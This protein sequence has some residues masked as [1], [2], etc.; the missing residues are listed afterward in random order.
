MTNKTALVT[1]GARRIGAAI[2]RELHASG[3]H[4]IVHYNE[5]SD[6][7]VSLVSKMNNIKPGSAWMIQADLSRTDCLQTLIDEACA[8]N[9]R[10]DVLVNNASRFYPTPLSGINNEQWHDIMT[11]NLQAPLL[12][13]RLAA[14]QLGRHAGSIINLTD[15]YA[16]RP[17]KNYL[18]Y[19]VSKAGLVMLTQSLARELAPDVRVNAVS[20]G[21]IVWPEG[22]TP[23]QQH[24]VLK[25]VP[26]G[27]EGEVTDVARAVRYLVFDADYTTGQ[28]LTMDGGRSLFP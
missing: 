12:L 19:S 18:L 10:L 2:C 20:P 22:M 7:A 5:S 26:L 8:L 1:G 9:G 28:V 25:R 27:R 4:V 14:D 24:E 11:V 6:E 17:L 23:D 13:S 16:D 21:A 15:I 3:L